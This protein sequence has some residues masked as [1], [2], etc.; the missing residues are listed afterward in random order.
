[1]AKI[2]QYFSLMAASARLDLGW[3]THDTFFCLVTMFSEF[4]ATVSSILGVFLLAVR[5]DGVGNLSANEVLFML[6]FYNMVQGFYA[7]FD[8]NNIGY[9]SRR[10]GRGQLDHSII[11][12]VSIPMQLLVDG[13]IPFTGSAPLLGGIAVTVAA[14]V[15]LGIVVTPL[16]VVHMV[17]LVLCAALVIYG[18]SYSIGVFAFYHPVGSEEISSAAVGTFFAIGSFPLGG[19]S[20]IFQSVLMSI[21]PVGLMAYLPATILLGKAPAFA[22]LWMVLAAFALMTLGVLLFQKGLKHYARFGSQRYKPFGYR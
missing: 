8:G 13:F 10:I 17:L 22:T 18:C 4:I 15:R 19:L 20:P 1:M 6:G 9:I 2:K 21:F 5:F 7:V 14:V 16:W 3:L 11:M 12:P